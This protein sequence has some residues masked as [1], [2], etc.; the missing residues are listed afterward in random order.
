MLKQKYGMSLFEESLN[1]FK[2]NETIEDS[3]LLPIPPKLKKKE[4]SIGFYSLLN[5]N[6]AVTSIEVSPFKLATAVIGTSQT[7][8]GYL[9]F[10][11]YS[12][13][14]A[15]RRVYRG[16]TRDELI[17]ISSDLWIIDRSGI[18]FDPPDSVFKTIREL[19]LTDSVS[20]FASE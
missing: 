14:G 11:K 1:V 8:Y 20:P 12:Q 16:L 5:L 6:Y 10:L 3:S 9:L 13:L 19:N 15:N 18:I 2:F 7:V 4:Y 17:L